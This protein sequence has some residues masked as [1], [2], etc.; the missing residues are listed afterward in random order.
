MEKMTNNRDL[1]D[2]KDVFFQQ[3]QNKDEFIE[4]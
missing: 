2:D 3:K 1:K 4:F